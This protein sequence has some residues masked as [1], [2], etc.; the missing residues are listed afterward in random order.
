[1]SHLED[2]RH[3]ER[4]CVVVRRLG[5]QR[6]RLDA[7]GHGRRHLDLLLLLVGTCN[8]QI[9]ACFAHAGRLA[10]VP[11]AGLDACKP[12]GAVSAH[13]QQA[14]PRTADVLE[15]PRETLR[16]GDG[17]AAAINLGGRPVTCNYHTCRRHRLQT[18]Q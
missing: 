18:K 1:M 11:A 13:D 2:L 10:L 16:H 5:K 15:Q 6:L 14:R 8:T 17:E 12:C 9:A 4:D 7:H 3:P